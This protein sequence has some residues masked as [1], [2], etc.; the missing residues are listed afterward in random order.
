MAK[1]DYYDVLGVS[2]N[3]SADEIKKSYRKLAMKYHPDR[4]PGDSAA[5]AQ[6]KEAAE[7]YEVL[8]DPEQKNNYDRYGFEGIKNTHHGFTDVN[9]IFS[10]FEDIFSSF[11]GFDFF[12]GSGRQS[13]RRTT[14]RGSDLEI[15][16][17]LTLNEIADGV[18]KKIKI[19]KV[20]RCDSCKGDGTAAGSKRIAC[21]VCGGAGEVR[22]ATRT[23]FG[24]F[25]NIS[26]CQNCAGKGSIPEKPC[27]ACDG[28]GRKQGET[29][30][31]VDIP[32]GVSTG[33]YLNLKGH[34]NAGPHGGPAGDAIVRIEETEDR[35]FERHGDEVLCNLKI[36]FPQAVLGAE[37]E[38]PTL[39]GK[40]VLSV[41]AGIQSGKILRM[42][43]KGIKH[44]QG[45]GRGDQLVRV[46][47]WIPS[48]IS[49]EEKKTF[50]KLL[51]SETLDP[52]KSDKGFFEKIKE[53]FI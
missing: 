31:S 3:A 29:V 41:P 1:R 12:G 7:A 8:S 43:G 20:V 38:V 45:S 35:I 10:H 9:D 27:P 2:K 13:S 18:S 6:F 30:V 26:Q 16:L 52:K 19:R 4:N 32:A 39:N 47:V 24:Q 28:D 42:R 44:L 46:L 33:H 22:Q 53:V 51:E 21:S 37:V 49:P 40:A 48:K 15:R 11:G 5:E 50:T 36:S 34:G 14:N 25:V 23:V 17:K